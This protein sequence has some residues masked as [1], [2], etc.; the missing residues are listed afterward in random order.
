MHGFS[1]SPKM[2]WLKILTERKTEL[3]KF[4]TKKMMKILDIAHNNQKF[5]DPSK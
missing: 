5:C 4:R 2:E 1:A 3:L